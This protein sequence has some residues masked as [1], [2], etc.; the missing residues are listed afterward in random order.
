MVT[1]YKNLIIN[2]NLVKLRK[3]VG[4][5]QEEFAITVKIKRSLLGAYEEMRAEV[6]SEVIFKCIKNGY[7]L[8]GQLFEFMFDSKFKPSPTKHYRKEWVQVTHE[9]NNQKSKTK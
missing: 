6:Q 1:Y 3:A 8:K 2:Q 4:L 7:L 5:T 9:V